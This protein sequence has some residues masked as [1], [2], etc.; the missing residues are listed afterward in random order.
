[1]N[2]LIKDDVFNNYTCVYNNLK[3]L[4]YYVNYLEILSLIKFDSNDKKTFI[5]RK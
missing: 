4:G 1:M 2:I 5:N 3:Y